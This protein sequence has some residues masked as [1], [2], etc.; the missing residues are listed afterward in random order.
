[1]LDKNGTV[2]AEDMTT[3]QNK[4]AKG[5]YYTTLANAPIIYGSNIFVLGNAMG[6]FRRGM[7]Q[8][9]ND[10]YK[11]ALSGRIIKKRATRD[12]AGNLQK[13]VFGDA[14]TGFT[15]WWNKVKA[16]GVTGNAALVAG[17]SLRYFAANVAE[18]IQEVS[19]E[20]VSG[21][22]K[23]YYTA[24]L[25]DPMAGGIEL[26]NDMILSAMGDQLSGEG[27]GTFMSG[28]L[29]GGIVQGPQ[30]LFFQGV[31]AIYEGRS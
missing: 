24:V 1:M 25:E 18:G 27:F 5:A 26:Q 30:K 31:P 4:A 3:I 9:F 22:T 17:A 20:A 13:S 11:R 23:G 8:M 28:F 29:M 21:A 6:G 2:T 12:A 10:T 7:G 14:G 15:G 19:Q 16:G